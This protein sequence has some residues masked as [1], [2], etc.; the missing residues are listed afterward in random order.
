MKIH[1]IIAYLPMAIVGL[2]LFACPARSSATIGGWFRSQFWQLTDSVVIDKLGAQAFDIVAKDK[3]PDLYIM[4][5]LERD[6]DSALF[7]SGYKVKKECDALLVG[8]YQ[9]F[10]FLLTD[11]RRFAG[12]KLIKTAF[13]PEYALRFKHRK[14]ICSILYS[15]NSYQLLIL[16]SDK[17]GA[18]SEKYVTLDDPS[19]FDRFFLMVTGTDTQNNRGMSS[20]IRY[21]SG[22]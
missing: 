4:S 2:L 9:V 1:K 10:R 3:H 16:V 11:R 13:N 19:A 21:Q 22:N 14:S 15:P 20:G 5:G 8:Q 7:L 12:N 18:R 6:R 17:S